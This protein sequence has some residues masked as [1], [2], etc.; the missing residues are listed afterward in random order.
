[1]NDPERRDAFKREL[2]KL[3]ITDYKQSRPRVCVSGERPY[4]GVRNFRIPDNFTSMMLTARRHDAHNRVFK[5][6]DEQLKHDDV[7]KGLGKFEDLFTEPPS[8]AISTKER[9]KKLKRISMKKFK[10][11]FVD[12]L[13]VTIPKRVRSR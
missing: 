5:N 12:F 4:E 7:L 9:F 3:R 1:M 13:D 10:G 2:R 6:D 8:E 11:G